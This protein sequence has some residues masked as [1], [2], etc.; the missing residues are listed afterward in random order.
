MEHPVP[1]KWG[2]VSVINDKSCNALL[3]VLLVC[4]GS[5]RKSVLRYEYL[6]LCTHRPDTL[7]LPEQGCED[8][9]LFFEAR[10]IPRANNSGKHWPVGGLSSWKILLWTCVTSQWSETHRIWGHWLDSCGSG[11]GPFCTRHWYFGFYKMRELILQLRTCWL[12]TL[13]GI[14][15]G[16][17]LRFSNLRFYFPV[18]VS[19][20]LYRNCLFC[21]ICFAV[22]IKAVMLLTYFIEIQGVVGFSF[23]CVILCKCCSSRNHWTLLA[24][25]LPSK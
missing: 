8:Q 7:Y 10:R 24:C 12:L 14:V 5:Y 18:F 3:R 16:T 15:T 1:T 20:H 11:G 21:H 23:C 9:W 22:C 2:T 6:M 13:T 4:I 19:A 17:C 25:L